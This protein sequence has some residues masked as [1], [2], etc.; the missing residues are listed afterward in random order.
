MPTSLKNTAAD[1]GTPQPAAQSEK[2]LRSAGVVS[3]AVM[4]SRV[5]GL[6]REMAMAWLFGASMAYDAFMLG[7]RIPNLTTLDQQVCQ[8]G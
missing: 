4:A 8:H 5:T 7:F 2:V 1:P 3:L 6:A